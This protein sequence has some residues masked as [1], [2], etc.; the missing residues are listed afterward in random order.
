M[1]KICILGS[2][3]S[4]GTQSLAVIRESQ[5]DFEVCGLAAG[6]NIQLLEEQILEFNPRYV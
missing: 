3:G 2:T 1:K 6:H 4:I 5:N